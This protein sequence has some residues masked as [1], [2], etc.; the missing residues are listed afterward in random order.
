[1]ILLVG[2]ESYWRLA[3]CSCAPV[4][5]V[6]AGPPMV[7]PTAMPVFTVDRPVTLA[8]SAHC[9]AMRGVPRVAALVLKTCWTAGCSEAEG[10]HNRGAV[11]RFPRGGSTF[12]PLVSAK[13]RERL[14][15]G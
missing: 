7:T 13:M 11:V 14:T 1:M 5:A 12:R 8:L 10:A 4:D 6:A 3:C 9:W 15:V 2:P